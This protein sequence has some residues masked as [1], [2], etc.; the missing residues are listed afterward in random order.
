MAG[1]N[2]SLTVSMLAD[3]SGLGTGLAQAEAQVR[4][5]ANRIG[6]TADSMSARFSKGLEG[7]F[8]KFAGP[9]FAAQIADRF[10]RSFMSA[11]EGNRPF[12]TALSNAFLNALESIPLI[13]MVGAALKSGGTVKGQGINAF[14]AVVNF[15]TKGELPFPEQLGGG[16]FRV[17]K[18]G[19]FAPAEDPVMQAAQLQA[20][21]E[22]LQGRLATNRPKTREDL[23]SDE[24]SRVMGGSMG[25]V[26]TAMGTFKFAQETS[27]AQAALVKAANEQ[28]DIMLQIQKAMDDLKKL[29]TAN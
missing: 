25:T 15:L 23:L 16:V 24:L 19:G 21:I 12:Q 11:L 17:G 3:S 20:R 1:G 29:T 28:V 5:S 18:G 10:G 13:G 9:A 4:Q 26:S 27:M 6:A 2:P 8:M 22:R 14:E 7:M